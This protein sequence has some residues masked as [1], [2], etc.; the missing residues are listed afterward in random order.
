MRHLAFSTFLALSTPSLVLG[1]GEPHHAITRAALEVLPAWQ[2]EVLGGEL[3]QLGDKYCM[4]P[5]HV[6]SDK[7]N[8]KYAQMESVPNE[9]YLKILHLPTQ[10]PEY[11]EVMRYFMEQAVA[12][13][14]SGKLGDAARYIGTVCHQIEDYGSPSHTVP[15]DNMFTLL[16]QFLP[17]TEA[18]KGQLMHGPIENG[19]FKVSIEG[20][21]PAL[22]GNTVNEAAWRLMHRVHDEILNARSTTV[23]I[24][25]A[26]Y[27]E[28]KEDVV[29]HQK[30][31]ATMDAQ[32]VADA[33]Y[34]MMCLGMQK[35]AA[36][37]QELLK[38]VQI[39]GFFPLEA[40]SCYYPQQQFFSS[41][42]WGHPRSGVIL[43]GGTKEIPLKLCVGSSNQEFKNGISAGMGKPLTFLLP[44]DVYARFTVLAGL[45]PELGAK[46]RVE[47]TVSGDGKVLTTVILNGTDP[48]KLLEC[49]VAGVR[50][51]Q[52]ALTSRGLDAKSNYAI[53]AEPTL[54]KN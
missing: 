50:E 40:A 1:W 15:G 4:I 22:L 32:V 28:D 16:Q 36:E 18:M 46:G 43:E 29:K 10:Q 48:A 45:H 12:S 54:V 34:T 41:P 37:E 35:F 39:G 20:Y 9:V 3:K 6:F 52:L 51:L 21:K 13:L 8:A 19:D 23:P 31:A 24:M 14:R 27:K 2:K 38:R 30:R 17:P 47:F 33:V 7:E 25:Q 44:K 5:D 53:W 42:N 11:L 26:L 49:D